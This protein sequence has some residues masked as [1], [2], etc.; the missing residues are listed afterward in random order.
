M[1]TELKLKRLRQTT[2]LKHFVCDKI[3]IVNREMFK[4]CDLLKDLKCCTKTLNV[5]TH[6]KY[7]SVP[8]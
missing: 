5:I 4:A 7:S 8:Q 6:V 2:K 3:K 1:N